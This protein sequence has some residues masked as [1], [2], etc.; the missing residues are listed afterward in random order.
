MIAYVGYQVWG[1]GLAT[2]AA[3]SRLR[4]DLTRTGYPERP[5]AGQPIGFIRIPRLGVD[6]AFVQGI[7]EDTL[8]RGPSRS[9]GKRRTASSTGGRWAWGWAAGPS[10]PGHLASSGASGRAVWGGSGRRRTTDSAASITAPRVNGSGW[11]RP[12]DQSSNWS[13]K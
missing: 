8:E 1:T 6:A 9:T 3:Q 4:S 7:D 11:S 13:L 2:A 12:V 10:L 5:E